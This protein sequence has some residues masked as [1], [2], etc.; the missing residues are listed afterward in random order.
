MWKKQSYELELGLDYPALVP[1]QRHWQ[2]EKE[3]PITW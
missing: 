1:G 3:K 2:R